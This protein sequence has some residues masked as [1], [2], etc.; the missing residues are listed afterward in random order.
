[1]TTV[2]IAYRADASAKFDRA[3]YVEA[4]L[5]LVRDAYGPLGL[6]SIDTFFPVEA[7]GGTI[8]L[9]IC[10]FRDDAAAK[11]A[12]GSP[13]AS[14]LKADLANFTNFATVRLRLSD[15]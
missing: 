14:E 1:M 11:T 9:A 4:H 6:E 3:Y 8:A 10:Q 7:G 15:L 2:I 5:P 12:F 13:R